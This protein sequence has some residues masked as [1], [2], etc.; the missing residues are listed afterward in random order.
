MKKTNMKEAQVITLD[1][2]WKSISPREILFT[3]KSVIKKQNENLKQKLEVSLWSDMENK[4]YPHR[5]VLVSNLIHDREAIMLYSPTGVGKTWLSLAI[6]MIV[7]GRGKLDLLDWENEDP[8][9]VCY[10]DGEMLE[11]DMQERIKM[12]IPSLN[13]DEEEL[14]KNFRYLS[15][16]SQPDEVDEFLSLDLEENQME[17]LRWLQESTEKGISPLVL[18][19]NLSNLVDLGVDN[20]AGQ[21]QPFNMMVTKAR[22]QGCSMGIIHHTG[23]AM[24]IGP[25]GIPTWRGSYDMATRLDKTICLLPCKSS[26]DGYV[27]FQVLEGK[28]RRGQRINMSI[29]FNPF[30]RRWE[31]FDES[32]TADRHQ[33]IKG[34]LENSCVSKIE[35]L[36]VIL[37]RSPSSAERYLKQA[38]ESEV[39]S[40][41]DWKTWKSEAKYNGGTKDERIQRGKKYLEENFRVLVNE[42]GRGGRYVVERKIFE[43]SGDF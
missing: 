19:D 31:L 18:L 15:R 25:D 2:K 36:S 43:D 9:P 5:K 20:S 8:Q 34:L 28:S 6:A 22:K 3:P 14:R 26:L 41:K 4:E 10:V 32:S 11:E 42:K 23:K 30:E 16:V 40:D 1:K 21:M 29:Q 27:T 39:F 33:L 37:E 12:L 35:D 13:V 38:I 17:L 24:T 7:A